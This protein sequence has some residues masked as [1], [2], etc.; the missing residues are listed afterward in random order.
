MFCE[1]HIKSATLSKSFGQG[2]ACLVYKPNRIAYQEVQKQL[3]KITVV[4]CKGMSE[5]GSLQSYYSLLQRNAKFRALFVGE[6]I[7][8]GGAWFTFVAS[9]AL[10]NQLSDSSSVAISIMLILRL[11]PG[12]ILFPITGAV[13]DTYDR[14][15]TMRFTCFFEAIVVSLCVFVNQS[16]QLP[17]LY[18]IIL[19]QFSSQSFYEP[20][21]RAIQPIIVD[22]QDLDIAT[23]LDTF[24]WSIMGAVGASVGGYLTSILGTSMCFLI[25]ALSYVIC[26]RIASTLIGV[27]LVKKE[28][29]TLNTS[30]S[31]VQ[32]GKQL[33]H[34]VKESLVCIKE[35][36]QYITSHGNWDIAC[37]CWLKGTGSL[38][39]GV[40]DVINVSMSQLPYMQQLGD[41]NK[42]LGIIF[43]TVGFGCL[44]GPLIFNRLLLPNAK[45]WLYGSVISLVCQSCGYL[46]VAAA[47][48]IYWALL[49]VVI[50]AVGSS[51]IW[52][53]STL[54][55][56]QRAQENMLGRVFSLELALCTL[57][58]SASVLIA[59]ILLDSVQLSIQTTCFMVSF[60][61]WIMVII[62]GVFTR[63][64]ISKM[65]VDGKALAV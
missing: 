55:I 27:P 47:P 43:A 63:W 64:Y 13:A 34:A 59:G 20:S 48:N 62:W 41:S 5:H 29:V 32:K 12:T 58:E 57:C 30:V 23:T 56:Q 45:N 17:L 52:V 35:G 25:D 44:I 24:S 50:R 38:I 54:I 65:E 16:A 60:L 42:T 1:L 31:H 2:G 3:N 7:N 10:V 61:G 6:V 40:A 19:L 4:R 37:L 14:A 8:A 21:R 28:E 36:Y 39:W 9:L 15:R 26:A 33:V 46:I 18:I 49:G 51:V 22:K 53:Y 11:L